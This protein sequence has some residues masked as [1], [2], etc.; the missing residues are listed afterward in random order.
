MEQFYSVIY[1]FLG[2]FLGILTP[3]ITKNISEKKDIEY[4]KKI[5]NEDLINLK[6]RI[7]PIPYLVYEKYGKFDESNFQWIISN[8]PEIFS[9][10]IN[11]LNT[12]GKSITDIVKYLNK[13]NS[14]PNSVNYFKKIN[15]F[16]IDSNFTNINILDKNLISKMLEV[17]FHV[18]SFNE[19][20]DRF[21]EYYYFTF[22][23]GITDH[24]LEIINN[25]LK[26]SSLL[27]SKLSIELVDKINNILLEI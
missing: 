24:N 15:I 21:R 16:A 12:E 23:P 3:S 18:Q 25:N 7:A 22:Q 9:D 6:K 2:W 17:K 8:S 27:I 13:Q 19:E 4:L 5:I 11:K 20:V 14:Q 10:P 26:D 1:I